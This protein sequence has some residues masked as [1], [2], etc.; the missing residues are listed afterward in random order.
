LEVDCSES[1]ALSLSDGTYTVTLTLPSESGSGYLVLKVGS[2]SY[3]TDFIG[4]H[5]QSEPQT[6]SFTL[7]MQ[8]GEDVDVV[9]MPRWGICASEF[10]VT[11]CGTLTLGTPST[12]GEAP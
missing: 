4:R 1:K 11:D 10:D 9:F 7:E 5:E 2:K 3:Y 8:N 12:E 6:L